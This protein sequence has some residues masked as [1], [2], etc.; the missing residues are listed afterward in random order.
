MR[1]TWRRP[2]TNTTR[3]KRRQ[4]HTKR[5]PRVNT[6]NAMQCHAIVVRN[7]QQILL[8][9]RGGFSLA[10]ICSGKRYKTEHMDDGVELCIR[11]ETVYIRQ[12]SVH[13]M[14]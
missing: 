9:T 10:A 4:F 8:F 11:Q 7:Y 2:L 1:R 3:L 6:A 14:K 12:E 13:I 5:G